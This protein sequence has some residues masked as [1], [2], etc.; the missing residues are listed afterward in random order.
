MPR[1]PL[2]RFLACGLCFACIAAGEA[3]PTRPPPAPGIKLPPVAPPPG[4]GPATTAATTA[5]TTPPKPTTAPLLLDTVLLANGQRI[6]GTVYAMQPDPDRLAIGTGSGILHVRREL[7][8]SIDYG[9]TARMGRVK[10]DDLPGLV[11]LAMWCRAMGYQ[12]QAMTLLAKAVA[13]PGCDLPTRA[14]FATLVDEMEGPER[15]LPLYAA[16]RAAGGDD[17]AIL[18]RLAELEQARADWEGKMRSAGLD[19]A[20]AEASGELA[21]SATSSA[22]ESGYEV[23]NWRSENPKFANPASCSQETILTPQGPRRVLRV[24]YTASPTEPRLDKAAIGLR[25]QLALTERTQLIL[26]AQNLTERDLRLA[27]AV[28]T[29][30]QWTYHESLSQTLPRPSNANEFSTITF[31]L[32]AATFKTQASGWANNARIGKLDQVCE[33]QILILNGRTS[34]TIRFAGVYFNRPDPSALPKK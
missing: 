17:P 21:M 2:T 16:Y 14:I 1:S 5:A 3:P 7:V 32:A 30:D 6:E 29:G 20:K 34:G 13:L 31:D 10:A 23:K 11:D 25:T 4:K 12:R 18:A 15:A 26:Q 19:P 22:V 28:K 33:L 9:L 8:A 24:E 27:V